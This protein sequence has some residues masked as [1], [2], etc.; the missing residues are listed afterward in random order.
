ML[1]GLLMTLYI[2]NCFFLVLVVLVQQGKGG[3][4]I[5]QLGGSQQMI[6][7]GSGGA[8]EL[9][10]ATWVLGTIFMFGSLA[11]AIFRSQQAR[12]AT[13]L[14]QHTAQVQQLPMLPTQPTDATE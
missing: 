1:F 13:H 11:L 6:F 4:G 10:K 7:G 2:L 3:L 5:T 9:Q 14:R 12:T 8:D